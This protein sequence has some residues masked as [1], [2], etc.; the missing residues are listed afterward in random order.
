MGSRGF[1]NAGTDETKGAGRSMQEGFAMDGTD[2]A[3]TK[4]SSEREKTEDVMEQVG[5]MIGKAKQFFATA[6]AGKH[7]STD[8]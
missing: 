8:G 6:Q 2:F 3:M 5:I 1:T 7:Q 4:K